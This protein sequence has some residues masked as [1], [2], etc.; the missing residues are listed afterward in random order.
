MLPLPAPHL[1]AHDAIYRFNV[2]PNKV[3]GVFFTKIEQTILKFLW[4]HKRHQI[5]K[6]ILRKKNKDRGISH[7]DFK[8]YYK[9]III[10]TM[11][12]P[13]IKTNTDQWN[14]IESPK[15]NPPIDN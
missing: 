3:S 1:P 12:L 6:A 7:P 4:N 15:V 13:Y 2:I 8:L 5:S 10:K 11:L 9:G 14:R